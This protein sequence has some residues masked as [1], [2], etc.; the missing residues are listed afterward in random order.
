MGGMKRQR[1]F[2]IIEVSLFLA[3]SAL[4]LS[5]L[6]F[7][8]QR[9]IG[10]MRFNDSVN[11]L[12]A[13]IQSQYEEVR[14]GVNTR[15]KG[16]ITGCSDVS[17]TSINCYMI[18]KVL[19]FNKD[20]S[21]VESKYVISKTTRL[22]DESMTDDAAV[23][24]SNLTMVDSGA[25][26]TEIQWGAEFIGGRLFSSSD[27]TLANSAVSIAIL[28]SPISSRVMLY[29]ST[30]TANMTEIMA[31]A[32]LDQPF[33]LIIKS[34]ENFGAK[35]AAICVEASGISSA[36][37]SVMPVDADIKSGGLKSRCAQ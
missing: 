37:H 10:Q 25:E 2:T 4:L 13:Y 14:S 31:G 7:G 1:G 33:G 20:Q 22:I 8:M 11:S 27:A 26:T 12:T 18:G 24:D 34:Q 36:V 6:V 23:K 16:A 15:G 30:S 28:H 17:G 21:S 19:I 32:Q 5:T 3:V 29:Y 9:M 35:A